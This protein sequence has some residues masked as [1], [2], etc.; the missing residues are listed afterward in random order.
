M[1]LSEKRK[2]RRVNLSR[3]LKR[4]YLVLTIAWCLWV[5]WWPVKA[6]NEE[7]K[8]DYLRASLT[9]DTC[10]A[11]ATNSYQQCSDQQEVA[12]AE[13]KRSTIDK[14]PYLWATDGSYAMLWLFPVVMLVPPA[15]V[16]GLLFAFTKLVLWIVNGFKV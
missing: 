12:L 2:M 5:L 6:R 14:N 10:R 1:D 15:M 4:I 3:G 11:L 7:Y 16:Y 8:G 13:A 9:F